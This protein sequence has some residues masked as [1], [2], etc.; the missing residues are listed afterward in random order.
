MRRGVE[1]MHSVSYQRH[2][3]AEG[4][5]RIA[6]VSSPECAVELLDEAIADVGH[7][8]SPACGWSHP[9]LRSCDSPASSIACA[10]VGRRGSTGST[11]GGYTTTKRLIRWQAVRQGEIR[12]V[13]P[14]PPDSVVPTSGNGIEPGAG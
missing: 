7:I 1:G 5:Q 9:L 11:A 12:A 3:I 4:L 8:S 2:A 10:V 6:L 13:A 14:V